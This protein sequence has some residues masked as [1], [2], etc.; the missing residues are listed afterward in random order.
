VLAH[1]GATHRAAGRSDAAR[2]TWRL[3]QEIRTDLG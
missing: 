3:A 1:L 2:A